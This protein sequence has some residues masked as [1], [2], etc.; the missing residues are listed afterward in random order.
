MGTVITVVGVHLALTQIR[1]KCVAIARDDLQ[2]AC[3]SRVSGF[4]RVQCTEQR[5]VTRTGVV[6]AGTALK[7]TVSHESGTEA[8][9]RK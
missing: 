8:I 7:P 5:V 1:V 9:Q 4:T 2:V 6:A 3:W